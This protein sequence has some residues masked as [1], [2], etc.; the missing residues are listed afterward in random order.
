MD[1]NKYYS[2]PKHFNAVFIMLLTTIDDKVKKNILISGQN[3]LGGG[4]NGKKS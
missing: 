1:Q 2:S 3:Y 4:G